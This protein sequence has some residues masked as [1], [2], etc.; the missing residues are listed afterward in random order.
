M[1]F[2][3]LKTSNSSCSL[4]YWFLMLL[5]YAYLVF[6]LFCF[7]TVILVRSILK[8]RKLLRGKNYTE[9]FNTNISAN[10]PD[11]NERPAF[12]CFQQA[13]FFKISTVSRKGDVI[14]LRS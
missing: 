3:L 8:S 2:S 1:L 9:E 13:T 4:G 12:W 11:Q 5:F 7:M 14:Y 6:N 10:I